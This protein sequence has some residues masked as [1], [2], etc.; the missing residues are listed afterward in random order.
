[1]S[2]HANLASLEGT[3]S[4]EVTL[5]L[6]RR[7]RKLNITNDH[8]TADLRFKVNNSEEWGTL[9][10]TESLSLDFWTRTIILSGTDI[11][12]RIWIFG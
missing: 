10:G 2:V 1:M 9:Q 12:Y 4:G 5:S 11:P 8:A 7:S 3:L 6:T